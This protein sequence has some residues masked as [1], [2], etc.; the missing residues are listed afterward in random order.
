MTLNDMIHRG[1]VFEAEGAGAGAAPAGEGAAPAAAAAAAA[2][3]AAAKWFEDAAYSPEERIWL[4]AKGLAEDDPMAAMPKL[5]KGHRAAE[6]RI[7]K[8]LDTI[9]EKP[10]KDQP[11]DEW[12]KANREALGLPADEAG[13]QVAPPENWPKDLPWDTGME[14]QAKA[15]ALKYGIPPAALQELVNMQAAS[16]MA[17]HGQVGAEVEA[18]KGALMADLQK[19]WG[20]QTQ[21]KITLAK[22]AA[23]AVAQAAGM[24]MQAIANMSELLMDKTGDAN[25]IRFMA[26]LGTMMADDVGTGIGKG[27]PMTMT[28]AEARQQRAQLMAPGGEY[29]KAT[30]ANDRAAIARLQPKMDHLAKIAAQG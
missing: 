5:I 17:A 18:A 19:D 23:Q 26:Q 3:A 12:V 22:Q 10:G 14:T 8:G 6:Q 15:V 9:I 13:Y 16:V 21:A 24:D 4:A 28:P 25:V 20:D 27:G 30:Q 11:Y 2:P 7:G 29:Y 1:R